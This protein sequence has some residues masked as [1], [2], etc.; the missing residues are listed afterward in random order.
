MIVKTITNYSELYHDLK[1]MGHENFTQDGAITLMGYLDET[2]E[3][4][5][6]EGPIEYDPIAFWRD[7]SEYADIEEFQ[8]DYGE[9]YETIEDIEDITTVISI[10]DGGFIIEDF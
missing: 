8:K 4:A 1:R 5:Y 7:Y 6:G 2:N 3:K 10:K 9:E